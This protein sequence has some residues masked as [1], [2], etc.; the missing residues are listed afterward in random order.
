MTQ[1]NASRRLFLRHAGAMSSLLGPAVAP[2]ALN[3][4]AVGSAA[5]QAASDYKALV[6]LF[7]FG[8]NDALNMVLPTDSASWANYSA[9]R[10]QAPDSIALLAPG[11]APN[12]GAAA[13]S[14]ARLGGV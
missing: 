4:S 5:A 1:P 12:A 2:F 11:T 7:M 9:V 6:C 14:P 3:L 10:N 8:G 13:G